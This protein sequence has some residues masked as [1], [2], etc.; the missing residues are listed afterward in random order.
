M[1]ALNPYLPVLI[2]LAAALIVLVLLA[3][4]R[5]PRRIGM[6][7]GRKAGGAVSRKRHGRHGADWRTDGGRRDAPAQTAYAEGSL[8]DRL[9]KLQAQSRA[10]GEKPAPDQMLQVVLTS[11][12]AKQ[13]LPAVFR[14]ASLA[15]W[16][17]LALWGFAGV[18]IL[19]SI[20]TGEADEGA[21][22]G[23]GFLAIPLMMGLAGRRALKRFQ[24][25]AA[26]RP[27]KKRR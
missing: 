11:K 17:W 19:V 12:E 2:G 10:T 14:F 9:T 3:R 18:M 20:A 8:H 16:A 27:G 21:I 7:E 6:G 4:G 13:A 25:R 5:G 24:A 22:V 1:E 15:L 26:A 23:L